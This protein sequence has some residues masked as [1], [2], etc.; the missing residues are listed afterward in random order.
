MHLRQVHTQCQRGAIHYQATNTEGK[1]MH[2]MHWDESTQTW[3]GQ[4]QPWQI[5][6]EPLHYAAWNKPLQVPN[7][8]LVPVAGQALHDLWQQLQ[9]QDLGAAVVG[10]ETYPMKEAPQDAQSAL[11]QLVQAM[12]AFAPPGAAQ[13]QEAWGHLAAQQQMVLWAVDS[14]QWA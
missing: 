4:A 5:G 6:Q 8:W 11:N 9:R 10:L 7:E 12:A 13:Q 2:N 14:S 3:R 1:T